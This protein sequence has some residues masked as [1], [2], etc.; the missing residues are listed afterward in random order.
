MHYG[1][2]DRGLEEGIFERYLGMV[3][4]SIG[5]MLFT[6]MTRAQGDLMPTYLT[7]NYRHAPSTRSLNPTGEPP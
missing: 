3:Y 5:G 2:V 6:Y 4:G 1:L 7:V